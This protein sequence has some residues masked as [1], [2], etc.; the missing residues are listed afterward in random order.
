MMKSLPRKIYRHESDKGSVIEF[1]MFGKHMHLFVPDAVYLPDNTSMYE[2]GVDIQRSKIPIYGTKVHPY[3]DVPK[4]LTDSELQKVLKA[5]RNDLSAKESTDIMVK[6]KSEMAIACRNIDIGVGKFSIPNAYE[7]AVILQEACALYK[8][9]PTIGKGWCKRIEKPML[10]HGYNSNGRASDIASSTGYFLSS[11]C[12]F[13]TYPKHFDRGTFIPV[14][15]LDVAPD[16]RL[17]P[18]QY[19]V[20]LQDVMHRFDKHLSTLKFDFIDSALSEY[21]AKISQADYDSLAADFTIFLDAVTKEL[22]QKLTPRTSEIETPSR[23]VYRHESDKG[24]VIEFDMYGKKMKMF[25]VDAAYRP[26]PTVVGTFGVDIHDLKYFDTE[27]SEFN[28]LQPSDSQLQGVFKELAKDLSAKENTDILVRYKSNAAK[29]CRNISIKELGNLDLPNLYELMVI[30]QEADTLDALDPTFNRHKHAGLGTNSNLGKFNYDH[31]WH[32][33]SS[34]L[35]GEYTVR[36]VDANGRASYSKFMSKA[37]K[38]GIIPIKE[39]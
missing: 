36:F 20:L 18:N 31:C 21:N 1:D 22:K 26:E 8:L 5:T 32:Y 13:D 10:M 39:L 30:Y 6:Q 28:K 17:S 19:Q 33:C 4:V 9:D 14:I 25:V 11:Y 24:S 23:K 27:Y 15:E 29:A 16:N 38:Y 34:T 3:D 37:D 7:L 2:Y 12:C 35:D